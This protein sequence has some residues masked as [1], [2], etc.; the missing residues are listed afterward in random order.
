M[1][2][3]NKCFTAGHATIEFGATRQVID[4]NFYNCTV[5]L[6]VYQ[7]VGVLVIGYCKF[8]S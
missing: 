2:K 1:C 4:R 5:K 8:N 6:L 3:N 7:K